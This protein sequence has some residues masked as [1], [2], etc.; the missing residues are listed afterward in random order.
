MTRL[1]SRDTVPPGWCDDGVPPKVT[2]VFDAADRTATGGALLGTCAQSVGAIEAGADWARTYS[3]APLRKPAT[4]AALPATMS[5]NH[6][7]T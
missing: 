2:P 5:A 6:D 7:G 3:A 4:L 1:G